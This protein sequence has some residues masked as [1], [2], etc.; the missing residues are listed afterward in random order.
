[1]KS[2]HPNPNHTFPPFKKFGS[3]TAQ[4]SLFRVTSACVESA[5]K[6]ARAAQ[7]FRTYGVFEATHHVKNIQISRTRHAPVYK[8][9]FI[10][11]GLNSY[12]GAISFGH[13][14]LNKVYSLLKYLL[15]EVLSCNYVYSAN[16]L[17]HCTNITAR[18]PFSCL[19]LL[20]NVDAAFQF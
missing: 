16:I 5:I 8:V 20:I 10:Y 3:T 1:M 13:N 7:S 2:Y 19:L 17:G 18:R 9:V 12:P 11:I 15:Y 6:A 4:T 14:N